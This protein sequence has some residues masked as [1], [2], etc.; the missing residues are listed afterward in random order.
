LLL[1]AVLTRSLRKEFFI[2]N[3]EGAYKLD[4][5]Y[6]VAFAGWS[7]DAIIIDLPLILYAAQPAGMPWTLY[8]HRTLILKMQKL[9]HLTAFMGPLP[10]AA[11][12]VWVWVGVWVL[13]G[14]KPLEAFE[15]IFTFYIR[16]RAKVYCFPQVRARQAALHC[17]YR[18]LFHFHAKG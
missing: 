5:E 15:K 17:Q 7:V 2:I 18:S 12:R 9:L 4:A 1:S 3:R 8:K 11:S 14:Q 16:C 6:F 10:A 13:R